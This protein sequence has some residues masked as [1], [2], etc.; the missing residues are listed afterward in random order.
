MEP[1]LRKKSL[2][3]IEM[4]LLTQNI[5]RTFAEVNNRWPLMTDRKLRHLKDLVFENRIQ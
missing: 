3:R 1:P 5:P 2:G 4:T